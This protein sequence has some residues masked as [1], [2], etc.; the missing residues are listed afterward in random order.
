MNTLMLVS[1]KGGTGRTTS[2]VCLAAAL[3]SRGKTLIVDEHQGH[4]A[5]IVFPGGEVWGVK[6]TGS[7]EWLERCRG[8]HLAFST[9]VPGLHL[10]AP[11]CPQDAAAL[12]S[13]G[14]GYSELDPESISGEYD[15]V[16]VDT[17]ARLNFHDPSGPLG[18]S[19]LL[20]RLQRAPH[21]VL[22]PVQAHPLAVES[23]MRTIA[24]L[25]E[26]VPGTARLLG[27]FLTMFE[28]GAEP[29][30]WTAAILEKQLP[31]LLFKTIVCRHE[32]AA[33][34]VAQEPITFSGQFSHLT[35]EYKD[36]TG[37]VCERLSA[38]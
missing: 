5:R 29:C 6:P 13:A 25:R 38:S 28:D 7:A 11:F 26:V 34:L 24:E 19:T 1:R 33:M 2:A 14:V 15:F 22:V 30:E 4:C 36:L 31:S 12:V 35:R 3:A 9:A 23:T 16:V 32:A 37:E 8:R 18:Y 20:A 17:A 27:V 21:Y 10:T